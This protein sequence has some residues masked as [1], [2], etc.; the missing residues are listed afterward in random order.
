MN[1]MS[2]FSG[3]ISTI[4]KP[5]VYWMKDTESGRVSVLVYIQEHRQNKCDPDHSKILAARA[6]DLATKQA[7]QIGLVLS[8]GV[9][10]GGNGKGVMTATGIADLPWSV[11]IEKKLSTSGIPQLQ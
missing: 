1:M 8:A 2:V 11:E 5:K 7:R 6:E 4:S 3:F 9:L 10:V